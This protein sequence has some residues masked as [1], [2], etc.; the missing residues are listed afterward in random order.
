MIL[1][2]EKASAILALALFCSL[3]HQVESAGVNSI[4]HL[5]CSTRH[6]RG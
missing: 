4:A 5:W 3:D 6:I 2:K 1:S